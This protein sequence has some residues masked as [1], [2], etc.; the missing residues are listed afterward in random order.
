MGADIYL[1][2]LYQ[3]NHDLY[4]PQFTEAAA[5]RDRLQNA[6]DEE[7]AEQVQTLVSDLYE[8]MYETGY[9]RDSYNDSNF[10]WLLDLS[11]WQPPLKY[12]RQGTWT[13]AKCKKILKIIDTR[14][15]NG[16]FQQNFLKKFAPDVLQEEDPK[17]IDAATESEAWRKFFIG[18][19]EKLTSLLRQAIDLNEPLE[20]SV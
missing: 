9:Y 4:Y 17:L 13:P 8:K 18:K 19:Y 7:G 2:S 20:C 11:W 15:Q 5:L 1:N 3:K 6:G 10:F 16:T 12:T 14:M